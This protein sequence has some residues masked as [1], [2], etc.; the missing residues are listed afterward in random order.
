MTE[1]PGD[2]TLGTATDPRAAP[3]G[4]GLAALIAGLLVAFNLLCQAVALSGLLFTGALALGVGL[5]TSLLIIS[6]IIATLA[7]ACVRGMPGMAVGALQ[8]VPV[9]ALLPAAIVLAT[10]GID[11]LTPTEAVATMLA[12]LGAS[13]F[14]LGSAMLALSALDL[15]RVVRLMPHP[16]SAGF[17]ASAGMILVLAGL[18]RVSGAAEPSLHGLLEAGASHGL[19]IALT[20]GLAGAMGLLARWRVDL[21]PMLGILLGIGG[22]YA[23]L[24]WQ[25][26]SPE[27]ARALDFLPPLVSRSDAIGWSP[28]L[29]TAVHWDTLWAQTPLILAAAMIGVL[30]AMLNFTGIELAL[31]S[32]IDTRG[33]LSATGLSNVALGLIGGSISY[34]SSVNTVSASLLGARGPMTRIVLVVGLGVGLVYAGE[35]VAFTPTFVAT[36]LLIYMGGTILS[37][38]LLSQWRDQPRADWAI[39]LSI[40]V[41]TVLFGILPAIALGI[42]T[43]SLIFAISYARLPVVTQLRDLTGQRSAV[44][45]GP[46]Q[47][48]QLDAQADKVLTLTLQGFL[49][50]GSVEQVLDHIR[51]ALGRP[52][53]PD[54]IILDFRKVSALDSAALAAMRKLEYLGEQHGT[55]IVIAGARPQLAAALLRIEA[56]LTDRSAVV[57]APSVDGAL[58]AAEDR[59]LADHAA[60]P[61]ADT[62]RSAIAD[63]LQDDA[64][65]ARLLTRMQRLDVAEGR[66]LITYGAE[67]EDIYVI[68]AGRLAVFAH[69]SDGRRMRVRSLRAGA[70]VGEI[71]SY[72]RLPRTADVVAE[73]PAVVYRI[74]PGTLDAVLS[75]DP[76]LAAAWHKMIAITLS[77]KIHRTTLMLRES[78]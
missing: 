6:C 1:L 4:D 32:E 52:N 49:F 10:G 75:E 20:L 29:F 23:V 59:L 43:A 42:V 16:V 28:A 17:L 77:E 21:G 11:G 35:I 27:D 34:V 54:T 22:F 5:S 18:Y 66:T 57:F 69:L 76:A 7:M 48:D 74:D 39:A 24:A 15:G 12:L 8:N 58:E 73:T 53:R 67:D 50:F 13:A 40:V 51:A 46:A 71:A 60:G 47:T 64:L 2:Q 78:V 30:G 38:W 3:K 55:E 72:A 68:E 62:A 31:R 44:D 36:A 61:W 56:M 63:A 14:V 37:R 9:A 65:A 33:A 26:L 45:R 19:A 25:G 70:I 41:V